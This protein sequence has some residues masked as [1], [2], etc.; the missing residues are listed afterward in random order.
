MKGDNTCSRHEHRPQSAPAAPPANSPRCTAPT[1]M[2]MAMANSAGRIRVAPARP[3]TRTRAGGQPAAASRRT[4]THFAIAGVR[5]IAEL[6]SR[7][8]SREFRVREQ[9]SPGRSHFNSRAPSFQQPSL[10]PVWGRG[11][12]TAVTRCTIRSPNAEGVQ[13]QSP[14]SS[15]RT[16][17]SER[18]LGRLGSL[19]A[20]WDLSDLIH[21]LPWP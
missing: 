13:H 4:S 2:P 9:K 10:P 15:Q 7:P 5:T 1:R 19:I 21:R 20:P 3:T 8:R 16:L 18:T 6:P 14:G 12:D 17:G 11:D